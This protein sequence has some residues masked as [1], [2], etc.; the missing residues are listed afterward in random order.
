VGKVLGLSARRDKPQNVLFG[1]PSLLGLFRQALPHGSLGR[2]NGTAFGRNPPKWGKRL[3]PTGRTKAER[4]GTLC[5][6]A[7]AGVMV[8]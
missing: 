5:A 2:P 1:D 8:A 7:A 3:V 4:L 6:G